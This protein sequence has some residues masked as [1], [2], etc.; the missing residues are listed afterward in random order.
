VELIP[1]EDL[2]AQTGGHVIPSAK[3]IRHA[4]EKALHSSRV[5]V[6]WYNHLWHGANQFSATDIATIA[7]N[8]LWGAVNF[9]LV[10]AAVDAL[11]WSPAEDEVV[12]IDELQVA[13]YPFRIYIP[14]AAK[15]RLRL[16]DEL[17]GHQALQRPASTELAAMADH[18]TRAFGLPLQR[19]LSQLRVGIIGLSGT[20]SHVKEE[21]AHLGVEDFVLCDPQTIELENLGRIIGATYED[22][23]NHSPKV[24]IA[25]RTITAIRPWAQV[26]A[27]EC[28]VFAPEA[29]QRL[30]AVD[31]LFGCTDNHSSRL[32]LNKLSRQYYLPYID[33]GTGIFVTQDGAVQK[34]TNM[35]GQ[36]HLM[37]PE[38]ACLTCRGALDRQAAGRELMD[39]EHRAVYRQQGY[40]IGD[41]IIQPQVIQLNGAIVSH[42][43][44][45]FINLFTSFKEYHSY[46]VYDAL[47]PGF[48]AISVK[49][50]P[51]CLH[52]NVAGIGDAQPVWDSPPQAPPA[53]ERTPATQSHNGNVPIHPPVPERNPG[54]VTAGAEHTTPVPSHK[55]PKHRVWRF[56]QGGIKK[57]LNPFRT[58]QT[59]GK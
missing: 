10:Q 14:T 12:P 47:Q 45:E 48:L 9:K 21:L 28:S 26:E 40:V 22:V 13:G 3:A 42:A 27:L 29:I 36:I 51:G 56:H 30:K 4:V 23:Q 39:E 31:M 53:V 5:L 38:S 59:S 8:F 55:T 49:T 41:E 52:C 54:R 6:H 15:K 44:T 7:Q 17:A 34:I 18:E 37:L 2:V 32:L 20:G 33:V 25:K 43:L 16:L 11:V 57:W 19:T 50:A 35:G 24:A 58:T 46:L 1:P